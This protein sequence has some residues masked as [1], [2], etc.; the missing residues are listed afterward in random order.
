MAR[1][2]GTPPPLGRHGRL[3]SA[4]ETSG[5]SEA[6]ERAAK[7]VAAVVGP[8]PSYVR[9]ETALPGVHRVFPCR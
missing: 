9:R 5:L 7:P 3:S 1:G 8:W 2:A 6:L 4:G